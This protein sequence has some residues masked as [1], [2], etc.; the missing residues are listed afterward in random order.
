MWDSN[1]CSCLLLLGSRQPIA[2]TSCSQQSGNSSAT[3]TKPTRPAT[4]VDLDV[5]LDLFYSGQF[6]N[7]LLHK[8]FT[9]QRYALTLW[10]KLKNDPQLTVKEGYGF[11]TDNSRSKAFSF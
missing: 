3:D 9:E 10:K 11:K 7:A 1:R 5:Y 2:T 4:F 8:Y 6:R